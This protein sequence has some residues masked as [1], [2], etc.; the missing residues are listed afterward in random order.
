MDELK[1]NIQTIMRN[2]L[3][4]IWN[5]QFLIFLF[6]LLLSSAFW[7]FQALNEVYEEDFKVD[8]EIKNVPDGVIITTEA[9]PQVDLCVRDRGVTLLNY[10]YGFQF[11]PIVIDYKKFANSTGHVRILTKELLRQVSSQLTSSTQVVATKP[12]TIEFFYN[13]G[14]HKRVPVVLEGDIKTE[15]GYTLMGNKLSMDSVTVYAASGLLDKIT[16]AKVKVDYLRNINEN[17][18]MNLEITAIRGAKF[19]P[20]QVNLDI[21]VD[22]LV[23]KRL[24]VPIETEGFP[25]NMILLPIPQ[26]TEVI[27]QVGMNRYNEITAKDFKV[28]ADFK[29]M[30]Q[31]STRRYPLQLRMTPQ[32]VSRARIAPNK[33]EYVIEKV[34]QPEPEV[35][36]QEAL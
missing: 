36:E 24:Q 1:S 6:F 34:A 22:R 11:H 27:F 8:V 3:S 28:V 17:T 2:C 15:S 5:K 25:S 30:P 31:N 9:V 20:E 10:K 13:H 23:E 4:K 33:V 35:Y 32:D 14:L 21:F 12:D 7:L 29:D 26:E 16:E 19:I 18:T